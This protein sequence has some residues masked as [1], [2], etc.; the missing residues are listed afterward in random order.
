[1]LEE[2][3]PSNGAT[4]VQTLQVPSTVVF[5]SRNGVVQSHAD[6]HWSNS[7]QVFTFTT[8]FDGTE[9]VEIS[10]VVGGL[11]SQ[12]PPGPTAGF[13]E[14]FRPASAATTVVLANPVSVILTIARAGVIQSQSDGHY[15]LA[16]QTLTF[17]D[18]F[19]GT[20]RVV[21][22][23]ISNTYV[24]PANIAGTIDTNLRT[25][26]L[27]KFGTLDPGGPPPVGGP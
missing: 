17:T 10:Y 4:T 21:V 3:L 11:G 26:V 22:A 23:Y 24:P 15:S 12:G 6:G 1:M 7:G 27:A 20:E 25:Y 16:G 19:D 14:E 13:H 5:V 2:F 9:R 18:A 8:A